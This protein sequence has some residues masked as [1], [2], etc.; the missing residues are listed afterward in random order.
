MHVVLP[1]QFIPWELFF[2]IFPSLF[3]SIL[4]YLCLFFFSFFLRAHIHTYIGP[5]QLHRICLH[6]A[7]ATGCPARGRT[8]DYLCM[9]NFRFLSG[10][11]RVLE[12]FEKRW[13]EREWAA[14]VVTSLPQNFY[15]C[16]V[17]KRDA[18]RTR[19]VYSNARIYCNR[20]VTF[21][22]NLKFLYLLFQPSSFHRASIILYF[23]Q[24]CD[25]F[26]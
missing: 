22:C 8:I 23:L 24:F 3:L 5:V 7:E 11:Q 6:F 19:A 1:C 15:S 10:T 20:R 2:C 26:Y 17:W 4:S 25:N 12:S 21:R 16:A 18:V 13:E 9:W 14:C